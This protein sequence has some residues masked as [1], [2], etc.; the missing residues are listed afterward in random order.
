MPP[1]QISAQQVLESITAL[2]NDK[3]AK[4]MSRNGDEAPAPKRAEEYKTSLERA[5]AQLKDG[6]P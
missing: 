4:Q 6:K 1:T 5:L 3:F 2:S